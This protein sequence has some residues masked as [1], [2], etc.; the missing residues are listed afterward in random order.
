MQEMKDTL[1]ILLE[2]KSVRHFTGEPV[3]RQDLEI[4][5]KAGMAAPSARNAQPWE[6]VVI[7]ERQVLDVL[8][9]GLPYAKMLFQAGAAI[10]VCAV[11]AQAHDQMVEYAVLDASAA[12]ENI[13]LAIEA[14]GLGGVWTALY[15]RSERMELVRQVL[16]IPEEILPFCAIPI[17]YPTGVD[18][19]KNKFNQDLIHWERW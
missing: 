18:R 6:F 5:L 17:G 8:A 3:R 1:T 10:V 16:K 13:L 2:R 19:P 15:P 14:I 7:T 12:T 11:I 4:I 9:D